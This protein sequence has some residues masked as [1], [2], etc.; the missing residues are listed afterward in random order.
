MLLVLQLKIINSWFVCMKI[1]RGMLS[2]VLSL[3]LWE[4]TV[5]KG[6]FLKGLEKQKPLLKKPGGRVLGEEGCWKLV[7]G[8][9]WE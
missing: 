6:W 9:G 4:Q 7:S 5:E 8:V 1:A 3:L 2:D